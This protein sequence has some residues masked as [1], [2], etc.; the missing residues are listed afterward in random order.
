MID[1]LLTLT[2]SDHEDQRSEALLTVKE[3]CAL[4]KRNRRHC[5]RRIKAGKMPDAHQ[6]AGQWYI[7]VPT[8]AVEA[9]KKRTAA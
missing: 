4:F 9:A 3:F 1:P 6:I 2:R 5:L 8:R 7:Y